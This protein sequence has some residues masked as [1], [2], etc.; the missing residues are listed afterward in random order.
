M[1]VPDMGNVR[2]EFAGPV[3]DEGRCFKATRERLVDLLEH[4]LNSS[5]RAGGGGQ[6]S[7]KQQQQKQNKK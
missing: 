3:V 7:Q 6:K 5:L 2:G 4:A 1:H